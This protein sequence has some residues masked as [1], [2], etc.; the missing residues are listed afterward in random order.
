MVRRSSVPGG[1]AEV[2]AVAVVPLP[3]CTGTR[4]RLDGDDDDD[5]TTTDDGDGGIPWSAKTTGNSHRRR[6]FPNPG[7]EALVLRAHVGVAVGAHV[8]VAVVVDGGGVDVVGV[9]RKSLPCDCFAVLLDGRF[10]T[11]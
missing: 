1:G 9:Y 8:A 11:L 7:D 5:G 10:R 4:L 3:R 2:A 6:L